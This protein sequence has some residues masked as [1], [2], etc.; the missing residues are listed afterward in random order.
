MSI[1]TKYPF[2]T[3]K[4]L[5]KLPKLCQSLPPESCKAVTAKN[6]FCTDY[7]VF[8]TNRPTTISLSY[9]FTVSS[10]I[11]QMFNFHLQMLFFKVSH[12]YECCFSARFLSN[13]TVRWILALLPAYFRFQHSPRTA[14]HPRPLLPVLRQATQWQKT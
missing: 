9:R 10:M 7:G 13:G 6:E 12:I 11:E 4:S 5:R 1:H 8:D 14:E 2:L 3:V